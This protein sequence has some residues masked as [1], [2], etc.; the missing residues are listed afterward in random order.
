MAALQHVV[1][2]G[3]ATLLVSSGKG[4][5]AALISRRSIPALAQL[6][7]KLRVID[8]DGLSAISAMS[9]FP[10][11]AHAFSP[12]KAGASRNQD[13]EMQ[14]LTAPGARP[15]PG[16]KGGTT[17]L[18]TLSGHS[19]CDPWRTARLRPVA[20]IRLPTG[21]AH[22]GRSQAETDFRLRYSVIGHP[23]LGSRSSG[24]GETPAQDTRPETSPP[25]RCD[26]TLSGAA[27][28]EQ[29]ISR[30]QKTHQ[31]TGCKR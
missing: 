29:G 24:C 19:A 6:L 15:T 3:K 30:R 14:A 22:G 18:A 12:A 2:G 28:S 27:P 13:F 17:P 7:I 25:R 8:A 31:N 9:A 10:P 21:S 26:P 4:T 11:F 20:D 23:V 5:V 1:L 16:N